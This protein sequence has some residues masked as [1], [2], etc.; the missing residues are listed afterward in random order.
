MFGKMA[1][2]AAA[3]ALTS[4]ISS[5]EIRLGEPLP[6]VVLN[7][8]SG[9]LLCNNGD[10]IYKEWKTSQLVGKIRVVYHLAAR[11]GV[12]KVNESLLQA[13][14][15]MSAIKDKYTTLNILNVDDCPF[16]CSGIA[17]KEYENS[18]KEDCTDEFVLDA[19]SQV[20]NAWGLKPKGSTVIVLGRD[21]KVL[22]FK[23]G[24]LSEGEMHQFVEIIK[25]RLK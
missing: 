21:G 9:E 8:R 6:E 17:R 1:I 2:V 15:S 22:A 18:R 13:L 23:D 20:K 24:K 25:S 7:D 19:A 16:L 3:L 5:G 10:V 11:L 12:N 14:D 4:N